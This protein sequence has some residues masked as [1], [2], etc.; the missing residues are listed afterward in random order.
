MNKR[1]RRKLVS[2]QLA[3]EEIYF[4]GTKMLQNPGQQKGRGAADASHVYR[5]RIVAKNQRG[6]IPGPPPKA[7]F[8]KTHIPATE[9]RGD[10]R[11]QQTELVRHGNR[12]CRL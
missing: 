11:I 10:I 5:L 4:H 8:A 2:R 3:V 12:S 6:T 7:L 9:V 1:T